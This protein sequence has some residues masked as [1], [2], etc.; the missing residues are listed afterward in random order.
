MSF[1]DKNVVVTGGTGALGQAVCGAFLAL[2]GTVHSSYIED[3]EIE[4]LPS[5]LTDCERFHT[6]RVE[7]TNETQVADWFAEIGAFDALV[8]IAGGF[9]MS[10]MVDTSLKDWRHMFDMNLETVYLTCREALRH[11]GGKNRGRIVN[12]GAFAAARKVA[13]MAAYTTSKAAVIHLTEVLAE[14]TI[15]TGV[16]VNAILPTIM[17]TPANRKAMPDAD[18][19]TWVPTGSVAE[20]IVFLC[21][22]DSWPITGACIPLR[23]HC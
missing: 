1:G 7:L 2:G 13:G 5:T 18:F 9:A 11:F 21:Q 22:D 14:E 17:D 23:G 10:P 4:R 20:T 3:R 16:T 12:I 6:K 8:N 15:A 19:S